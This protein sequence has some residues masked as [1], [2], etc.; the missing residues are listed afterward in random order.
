MTFYLAIWKTNQHDKITNDREIQLPIARIYAVYRNV[1]VSSTWYPGDL[2][3]AFGY[4]LTRGRTDYDP[5]IDPLKPRKNGVNP[6]ID[7][8]H[9]R[10]G[11]YILHH[12]KFLD[13]RNEGIENNQKLRQSCCPKMDLL[14]PF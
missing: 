7:H 10:F 8:P 6:T 1:R 2:A 9:L 12:P 4:Q 3:D 13:V 14:F 11:D 5:F